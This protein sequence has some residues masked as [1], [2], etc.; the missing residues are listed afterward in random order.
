[1]TLQD[2]CSA[3]CPCSDFDCVSPSAAPTTTAMT[4]T[5][6]LI[7]PTLT[8]TTS[9][10]TTTATTISPTRSAVLVLSTWYY[11]RNKP[12]IVDFDGKYFILLS[13]INFRCLGNINQDLDFEYGDG[14]YA[15][16]G[17]GATLQNVFWY[18]GGDKYSSSGSSR[19]V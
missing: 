13:I 14:V 17:C 1:M 10:E 2:N 9:M 8:T 4:A 18:F 19:K 5:T 11:P 12:F 15:V 7:T 3:G 16:L 6:S